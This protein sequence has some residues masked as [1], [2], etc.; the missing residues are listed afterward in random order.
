M[1]PMQFRAAFSGCREAIQGQFGSILFCA[2]G[3]GKIGCYHLIQ[4]RKTKT[5]HL[6]YISCRHSFSRKYTKKTLLQMR[7]HTWT[8]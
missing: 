7:L 4:Q 8:L 6:A 2:L 1:L 5:P 3:D